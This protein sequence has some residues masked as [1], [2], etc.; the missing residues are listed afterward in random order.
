VAL[1][2]FAYQK[3]PSFFPGIL[4]EI[5]SSMKIEAEGAGKE[6]PGGVEVRCWRTKAA[7]RKQGGRK[8]KKQIYALMAGVYLLLIGLATAF[9]GEH[10]LGPY[11]GSKEFERMKELAGVWEG[12]SNMPK[13]GD[14]VKVEYRLSSGGSSIVEILFPGAPHEMVSVY[15]DNKGQLTMTHYCALRNQPR[16]KLQKADAQNLNFM[17]AGG[18]NIDSKKDAY[19]RSLTITFVDKN[20]IIEKWTLFK[21]GKE[22]ETSVFELSRVMR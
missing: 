16:M 6:R 8:M 1:R 12:T 17:F 9:A 11:S 4:W 20:H 10:S 13:E 5:G 21:E 18:T 7:K 22:Q 15:F 2:F 3:S 14:K 19:M